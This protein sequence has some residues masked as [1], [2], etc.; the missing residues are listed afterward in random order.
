MIKKYKLKF[1][2]KPWIS[3]GLQK[4]ISVKNSIFKKNI[5]KRDP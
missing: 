2:E 3:F 1:K 5:N 4:S